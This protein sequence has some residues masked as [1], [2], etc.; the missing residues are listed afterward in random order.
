MP[1]RASF[2]SVETPSRR[3]RAADGV[4]DGVHFHARAGELL[5]EAD[6]RGVVVAGPRLVESRPSARGV[7]I[8]QLGGRTLPLESAVASTPLRRIWRSARAGCRPVI[9][10]VERAARLLGRRP[11]P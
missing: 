7:E 5:G 3:S 4:A 2:P 10:E 6:L 8:Y 11:R 1:E 9:A